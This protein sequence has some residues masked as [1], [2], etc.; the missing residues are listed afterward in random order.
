[1]RC[2]VLTCFAGQAEQKSE[3]RGKLSVLPEDRCSLLLRQKPKV[4]CCVLR[5]NEIQDLGARTWARW[6]AL[7]AA[8]LQGR[9]EITGQKPKMDTEKDI[10]F[11]ERVCSN[12]SCLRRRLVVLSPS[13]LP[14]LLLAATAERQ[15]RQG[16]DHFSRL[17]LASTGL[18]G[19]DVL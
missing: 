11:G 15:R 17:G 1:M 7:V 8:A 5:A 12:N 9:Q 4:R 18:K 13:S 16:W 10:T 14:I 6:T 3:T 2:S 19:A